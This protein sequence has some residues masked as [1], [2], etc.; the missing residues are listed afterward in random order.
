MVKESTR[1]TLDILDVPLAIFA[2]KLAVPSA[3][4]LALEPD[5]GSRRLVALGVG[6]GLGI[7]LGISTHANH[8]VTSRECSGDGREGE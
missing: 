7:P 6:H 3:D 8:L 5:G 1:G 4:N 2:P